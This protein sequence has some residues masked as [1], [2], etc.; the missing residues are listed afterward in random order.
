MQILC[1]KH[2]ASRVVQQSGVSDVLHFDFRWPGQR[3]AF[4]VCGV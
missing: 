4:S 3:V 1:I 2:L